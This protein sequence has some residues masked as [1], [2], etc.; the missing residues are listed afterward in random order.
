VSNATT[1]G[2]NVI[3]LPRFG[4]GGAGVTNV[5]TNALYYIPTTVDLSALAYQGVSGS[6]VC[7]AM[8]EGVPAETVTEQLMF[9]AGYESAANVLTGGGSP[10][11]VSPGI[12]GA[13]SRVGLT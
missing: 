1:Y 10:S 13:D 2:L 5:P 9:Q 4:W 12:T 8:V 11:A 3:I 7:R 6:T